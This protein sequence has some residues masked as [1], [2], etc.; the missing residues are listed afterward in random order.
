MEFK[1]GDGTIIYCKD[2]YHKEYNPWNSLSYMLSA[3]RFYYKGY[4]VHRE[5]EPAIKWADGGKEWWLNGQ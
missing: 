4:L 3:D 2:D 5:D 1:S